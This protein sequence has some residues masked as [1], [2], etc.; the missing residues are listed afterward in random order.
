MTFRQRSSCNAPL[1]LPPCTMLVFLRSRWALVI[2]CGADDAQAQMR[3]LCRVGRKVVHF[4]SLDEPGEYCSVL[5]FVTIPVE[6]LFPTDDV[7]F[8]WETSRVL[9]HSCSFG[10]STAPEAAPSNPTGGECGRLK[11]QLHTCTLPDDQSRRSW[12]RIKVKKVRGE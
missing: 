1:R 10:V 8:Q 5:V 9:V 2:S 4:F 6:R 12:H 3:R 7:S 11:S